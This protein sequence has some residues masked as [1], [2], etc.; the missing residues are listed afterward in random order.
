MCI[1]N[2]PTQRYTSPHQTYTREVQAGCSIPRDMQAGCYS[3]P[4]STPAA[5][6]RHLPLLHLSSMG[7]RTTPHYM[8]LSPRLR[9]VASHW[10]RLRTAAHQL[11]HSTLHQLVGRRRQLSGK[12]G[13]SSGCGGGRGWGRGEACRCARKQMASHAERRITELLGCTL[14]IH[15]Q[16]LRTTAARH[17]TAQQGQQT[18]LSAAGLAEPA[19]EGSDGQLAAA[20]W[21]GRPQ[22]PGQ[23]LEQ[24][25][26]RC[27]G[28]LARCRWRQALR[29]A[30]GRS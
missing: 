11:S 24:R 10:S 9:C 5:G 28:L 7:Q 20:V 4:A 19:A 12:R 2:R 18:C 15:R 13:A 16:M 26:C 1:A 22:G 27:L 3:I 8:C 23:R 14:K 6:A 25:G 30:A 29:V 17:S 21:V